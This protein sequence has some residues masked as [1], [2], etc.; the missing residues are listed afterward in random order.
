MCEIEKSEFVFQISE[1][2]GYQVNHPWNDPQEIHHLHH[3]L[4]QQSVSSE[5]VKLVTEYGFDV[6]FNDL[7]KDSCTFISMLLFYDRLW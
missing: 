7:L 4:G 6:M 5:Q 1:I 3:F 2:A